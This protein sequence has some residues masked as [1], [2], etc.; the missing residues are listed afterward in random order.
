VWEERSAGSMLSLE[1]GG[2]KP[3]RR[4]SARKKKRGLEC[5]ADP[6]PARLSGRGV[7]KRGGVTLV[8]QFQGEGERS[9]SVGGEKRC[10]TKP[11]SWGDRFGVPKG[12][13]KNEGGGGGG[14]GG[15]GCCLPGNPLRGEKG[16]GGG[17]GS[18]IF[19]NKET[20]PPHRKREPL[21]T[22]WSCRGGKT[23]LSFVIGR[24]REIKDESFTSEKRKKEEGVR[25][26]V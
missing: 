25:Q 15:G 9:P 18:S 24:R 21:I 16:G 12:K 22:S 6:N 5:K 8:P 3:F 11:V 26:M 10:R 1:N 17:N 19:P 2:K 4:S 7:L 14:G 20:L 23:S 13:K